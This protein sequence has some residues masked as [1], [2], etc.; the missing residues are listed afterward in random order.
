MWLTVN[1]NDLNPIWMGSC[2]P[3]GC[4][5]DDFSRNINTYLSQYAVGDEWKG[6]RIYGYTDEGLCAEED[7]HPKVYR[8]SHDWS[9]ESYVIV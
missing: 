1:N 6:L 5:A 7:G 9:T 3:S 8:S 4:S 2:M